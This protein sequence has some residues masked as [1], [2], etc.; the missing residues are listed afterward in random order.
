MCLCVGQKI[1]QQTPFFGFFFSLCLFVFFLL[2]ETNTFPLP[3]MEDSVNI[4]ILKFL[5]C[6]LVII[7][8]TPTERDQ[9][10]LNTWH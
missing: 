1:D 8:F 4:H 6:F 9:V 3:I 7:V 5:Y 2:Q 10:G